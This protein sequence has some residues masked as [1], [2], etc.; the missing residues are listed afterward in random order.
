M[1]ASQHWHGSDYVS[2]LASSRDDARADRW[3]QDFLIPDEWLLANLHRPVWDLAAECE[4]YDEWIKAKME[5][6]RRQ[7]MP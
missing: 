1:G 2:T 3:A 5:R 7:F 4:V 6:I